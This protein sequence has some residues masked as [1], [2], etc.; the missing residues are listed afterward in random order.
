MTWCLG[1]SQ[2]L[3]LDV[4]SHAATTDPILGL[5]QG[6]TG[7]HDRASLERSHVCKFCLLLHCH[8]RRLSGEFL[9]L[10]LRLHVTKG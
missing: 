7:W 9:W 5:R 6:I 3:I 2:L 10:F 1:L 8:W 4:V